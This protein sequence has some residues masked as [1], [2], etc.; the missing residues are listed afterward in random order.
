LKK[1]SVIIT[2]AGMGRRLGGERPKQFHILGGQPV[3]SHTL[4]AF[5]LDGITEI[6]VTVPR[7]YLKFTEKEIVPGNKKIT[8]VISGGAD[9]QS[10]VYTA[11][12]TVDPC[13]D[14]VLVHDGVRPFVSEKTI[15]DVIS[16]AAEGY[17]AVAGVR[18]TDTM[19]QS[20]P[21]GWV[22]STPD[23]DTLWH[24]Q[25]PQGF[26]YKVIHKAHELAARDGYAG[27]DDSILVERYKLARV[28]MV[29]GERRN[30]KI[31]TAED[32][33]YGEAILN[34]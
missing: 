20:D 3:L 32:M 8:A 18:A 7:T 28:K 4:A 15:R 34:T 30:I 33:I 1:V 26:P 23:R 11:L 27:T 12:K 14:I 21:E 16:C 25:T 29:S 17:A 5:S 24:V 31:T 2:A 19:K 13:T 10:S 6:I 9:R 22:Y